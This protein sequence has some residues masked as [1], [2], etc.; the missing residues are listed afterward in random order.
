MIRYELQK[1]TLPDDLP[2]VELSKWMIIGVFDTIYDA[3]QAYIDNTL[4]YKDRE[5]QI[6]QWKGEVIS[7]SKLEPITA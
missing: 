5:F 2:G 4:G 3:E 7:S 6:V 1:E